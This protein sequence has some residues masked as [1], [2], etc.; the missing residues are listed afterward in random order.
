MR[1]FFL[2]LCYNLSELVSG[3]VIQQDHS[4]HP[5]KKITQ[6]VIEKWDK[7]EGLPG[8]AI[9]NIIQSNEGYIWVVG[10]NGLIR[11]DGF[12][13]HTYNSSN[14]P[15]I[16]SNNIYDIKIDQQGNFYMALHKGGVVKYSNGKFENLC[17]DGN[18]PHVV[19]CLWLDRKS[20]KIW[21][22]TRE[23]GV[24]YIENRRF[25]PIQNDILKNVTVSQMTQD[26]LNGLWIGTENIGLVYYQDGKISI[27]D[28]LDNKEVRRINSVYL[29]KKN[30]LLVGTEY[31]LCQL[32]N[33][34][35]VLI[36]ELKGVLVNDII[37]DTYGCWWMAT[38]SGLVRKNTFTN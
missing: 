6:Y 19:Q 14:T 38:N 36:K 35:L 34:K 9:E 23:R 12:D 32:S 11:F 10:F 17:P 33:E 22:G 37:E 28:K 31:G 3:Q 13:F 7:N 25:L 4:L 16:T 26:S 30:E 29:S 2:L 20:E 8:N 27:W 21:L 18:F 15:A 1:F 24:F 5:Q